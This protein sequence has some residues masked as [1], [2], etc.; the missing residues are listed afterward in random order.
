M[1]KTNLRA[2]AET[3]PVHCESLTF[4]ICADAIISTH[5]QFLFYFCI[6]FYLSCSAL[7][8]SLTEVLLK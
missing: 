6:Y 7:Y 5:L 3:Q 8:Y 1:V 2:T 4:T